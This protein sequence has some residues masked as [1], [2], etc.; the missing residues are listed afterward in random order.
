M[1]R[2]GI[3]LTSLSHSTQFKLNHISLHYP[4]SNGDHRRLHHRHPSRGHPRESPSSSPRLP[5]QLLYSHHHTKKNSNN[6]GKS[7]ETPPGTC[8]TVWRTRT[9]ERI[10]RRCPQ[11]QSQSQV[12]PS[13]NKRAKPAFS[14]WERGAWQRSKELTFY[15]LYLWSY[16]RIIWNVGFSCHFYV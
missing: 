13:S 2:G 9:M 11:S 14:R 10:R 7:L 4:R 1:K 12:T 8:I 16:F 5:A 15:N 6:L 3:N